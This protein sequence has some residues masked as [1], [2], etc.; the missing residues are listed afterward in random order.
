[1][2]KGFSRFT[3]YLKQVSDLME[4]ARIE[5][6]PAMWLFSNNART[7]FFMLEA[8]ARM[9][10]GIHNRKKFDKLRIRF[11]LIEDGFGKIDYFNSLTLA[12]E[13]NKRINAECLNYVRRMMEE[14][15]ARLNDLLL[16][17]EWLS[18]KHV[19]IDKI[20]KKLESAEWL[21]PGREVG[22]IAEFYEA[23]IENI[24]EF[25]S[26]TRY[27]FD[28]V[29]EDVHELRRRLRWLSIYPQSMQGVF[30]FDAAS[31]TRPYL[32]KYLTKEITES[33]YNKLPP[34]GS[35]TSF[36]ILNKNY[37][38]ALSWMIARLGELKDEGLLITGLAEAIK[39]NSGCIDK[40]AINEAYSMSGVKQKRLQQILDEA[41]VITKKFFREKNLRHLLIRTNKAKK[42]IIQAETA[43]M[44]KQKSV[45]K[46]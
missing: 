23:S 39:H 22:E 31:P 17:D 25:V 29:E 7:P 19:R 3:F 15:S 5:K 24:N 30:Q 18:D 13:S 43:K 21:K 42:K 32:N 12:F 40:D 16:Q 9:Y 46:S 45:L 37:F 27:L 33:P 4:K 10:A 14:S 41:E 26:K 36:V 11:K 6:D 2:K 28:N 20:T 34:P 1:M 35:N 38:L 8:L 44:R